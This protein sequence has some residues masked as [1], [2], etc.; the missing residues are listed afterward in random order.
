MVARYSG[1]HSIRGGALV[2]DFTVYNDVFCQSNKLFLIFV[3]DLLIILF[4]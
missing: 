3:A 4:N 1:G 2:R